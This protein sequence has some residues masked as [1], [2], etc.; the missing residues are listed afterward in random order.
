MKKF[1]SV[2]LAGALAFTLAG[3]GATAT[4]SPNASAETATGETASLEGTTLKVAASPTP[5]A[6]ILEIAKQILAEQG[7]ERLIV[8]FRVELH[9]Q[10]V[11]E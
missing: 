11:G 2:I 8:A 5:H 9:Q 10:F 7:I 4:I 3:C 6:E 1:L